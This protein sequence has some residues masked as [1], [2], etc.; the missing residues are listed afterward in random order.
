MWGCIIDMIELFKR[1]VVPSLYVR[2]Y[3]WQTFRA[4][5]NRS[6]ITVCEG[7]S[8]AAAQVERMSQF[9]HCMWGCIG[10][11]NY[12][13]QAGFVPSLYV[14]VYRFLWY[15]SLPEA[16]S[17]TV[18]EGISEKQDDVKKS[19]QFPH[20]MWGCITYEHVV[21]LIK[22]VPSL[23]VRVYHVGFP[24]GLKINSSLTVCEGIYP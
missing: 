12:N 24:K 16:S 3:R 4:W 9:P 14:R 21:K 8:T 6:S 17:L 10:N 15:I 1:N 19:M 20:C 23:Y 11:H 7:V 2:V 13:K 5:R 18:C 22:D